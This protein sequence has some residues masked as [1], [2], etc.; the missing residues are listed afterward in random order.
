MALDHQHSV[1]PIQSSSDVAIIQVL[2]WELL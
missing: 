1:R 2:E